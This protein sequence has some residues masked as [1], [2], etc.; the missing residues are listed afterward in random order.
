M[1]SIQT[2]HYNNIFEESLGR[3]FRSIEARSM[4]ALKNLLSFGNA[5]AN[6]LITI[7]LFL[8]SRNGHG[9]LRFSST[10]KKRKFEV[11]DPSSSSF[12]SLEKK[13][14]SHKPRNLFFLDNIW[15]TKST[16]VKNH[17]TFQTF[18]HIGKRDRFQFIFSENSI[19]G[20]NIQM[21]FL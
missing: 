1:I 2:Y 14:T 17:G 4:L 6:H 21:Y 19:F 13:K 15:S 11:I 10:T 9:P 12:F 16:L 3:K 18:I 5:T 8:Y 20:A 7:W